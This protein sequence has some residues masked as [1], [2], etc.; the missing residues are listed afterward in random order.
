MYIIIIIIFQ[1]NACRT[2]GTTNR[3]CGYYGAVS[4][5]T[6][7]RVTAADNASRSGTNN[8]GSNGDA[9]LTAMVAN[10]TAM[11]QH[12]NLLTAFTARAPAAGGQPAVNVVIAPPEN[13]PH[14]NPLAPSDRNL[15]KRY[16]EFKPHEFHGNG[17]LK[18]EEDWIRAIDRIFKVMGCTDLRK[19]LLA[20]FLCEATNRF[21]G[22]LPKCSTAELENNP[23]ERLPESDAHHVHSSGRAR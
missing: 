3:S 8:E 21:G 23:Y 13:T 11:Q 18:D 12:S 14:M 2:N 22:S 19:V 10:L 16:G 1:W 4:D 15:Y 7:R 9:K 17:G 20:A 5:G 6:K